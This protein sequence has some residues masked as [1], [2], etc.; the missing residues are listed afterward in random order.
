MLAPCGA[1]HRA[2][3]RRWFEFTPCRAWA[4]GA[5]PLP[6]G[7]APIPPAVAAASRSRLAALQPAVVGAAR[8]ELRAMLGRAPQTLAGYEAAAVAAASNGAPRELVALLRAAADS[9]WASAI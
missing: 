7:D 3:N 4:A 1:T 6:Y 2:Q 5:D 9:T 8:A